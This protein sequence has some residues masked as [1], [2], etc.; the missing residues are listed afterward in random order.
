EAA[1]WLAGYF[2]LWHPAVLATIA[3][4]PVVSSSY[5]HDQPGE[6]NVYVVPEGPQLYQPDDWPQRVHQAKAVAFRAAPD[7]AVTLDTLKQACRDADRESPGFDLPAET[8][9]LFAGLGYGYLLV[10]TL[11]DAAE[12]D[13]L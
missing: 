11:F 4:P 8:V 9:R 5:D 6:G 3:R 2:A 10:E 1:S 7:R 12:H 13:H